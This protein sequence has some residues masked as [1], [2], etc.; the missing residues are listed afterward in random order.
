[1]SR[2]KDECNEWAR[3]R[4]D[5]DRERRA[6]ADRMAK[7]AKAEWAPHMATASQ[8]MQDAL[9]M[10]EGVI[11]AGEG[12]LTEMGEFPDVEYKVS[13]IRAARA[14]TDETLGRHASPEFTQSPPILSASY[15]LP[16]RDLLFTHHRSPESRPVR[17]RSLEF[18]QYRRFSRPH[19]AR[20]RLF[21]HYERCTT[22]RPDS[23]APR[24][25]KCRSDTSVGRGY[26]GCG[27]CSTGPSQSVD[28]CNTPQTRCDS[29][30][31]LGGGHD[32][33]TS[34]AGGQKR[35]SCCG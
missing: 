15:A 8:W 17:R 21:F 32:A 28:K 14:V 33:S 24:P 13:H 23:H 9:D 2:C 5:T 18:P 1:M 11:E 27:V 35:D 25:R 6:T 10:A 26:R 19:F 12:D 31:R 20:S 22:S 29:P 3:L 7:K 30:T 34:R 4:L 16:G